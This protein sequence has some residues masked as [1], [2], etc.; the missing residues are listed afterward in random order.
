MSSSA[1]PSLTTAETEVAEA[2]SAS[3]ACCPG[4]VQGG[5][6]D[7]FCPAFHRAVELIGRRWTGVVLRAMLQGATRY[8]EIRAAVPDLSDKM[9]A[10]R[11]KELEAERVVS[12]V[13]IPSTPVRVEYHLT[14]K[15]RALDAAVTAVAAWADA[16][17]PGASSKG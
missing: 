10:E 2:E 13:V 9:L 5:G 6:R 12:R 3:A 17:M 15:G 11:L 14:E 4:A 8:S 7:G 16:W 1:I